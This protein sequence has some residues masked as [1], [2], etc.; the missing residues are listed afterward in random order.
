MGAVMDEPT[1]SCFI[2]TAIARF[3]TRHERWSSRVQPRA[4][5]RLELLRG[6]PVRAVLRGRDRSNAILLPGGD[7][8]TCSNV[9]RLVPTQ[10]RQQVSASVRCRRSQGSEK[11][12]RP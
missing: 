2:Q 5:E 7:E 12:E 10:L 3:T 1:G 11:R 6:K 9:T 4:F 8:E